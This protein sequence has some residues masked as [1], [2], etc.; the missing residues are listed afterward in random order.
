MIKVGDRV[1]WRSLGRAG[2]RT[3]EGVVR[4]HLPPGRRAR[5]PADAR[6]KAAAVNSVHDRYLIE[7]RRWDVRS[8]RRLPSHWLAP[9]S[10]WLEK[11]LLS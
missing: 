9:K 7:V 10:R 5:L 1:R 11:N 3:R 2:S 8:G 6:F 4:A